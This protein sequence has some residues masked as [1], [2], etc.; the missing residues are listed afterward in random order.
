MIKL[1]SSGCAY[2]SRVRLVTLEILIASLKLIVIRND[3]SVL[4]DEHFAAVEEAREESVLILRWDKYFK[5]RWKL[6]DAMQEFLQK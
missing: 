1:A 2:D 5:E 6:V 3:K 4:A